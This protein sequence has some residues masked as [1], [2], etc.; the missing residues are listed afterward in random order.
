[1]RIVSRQGLVVLL[2]VVG[3]TAILAWEFLAPSKVEHPV[4]A[5]PPDGRALY[6]AHCAVCHGQT[7]KGDGP[8]MRVVRQPLLDFTDAA[9]MQ[10]RDDRFLAEIIKKGGSQ[11]GRSNAMPA[12]SMK[13]SDEEIHAIVAYIRSLARPTAAAASGA[14]G[15]ETP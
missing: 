13:L 11:F 15:K 12:W 3:V 6:D 1:M 10:T 9:A 4:V 8:G 14:R 7:G 2:A 5:G